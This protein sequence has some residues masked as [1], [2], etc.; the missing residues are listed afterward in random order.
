MVV[1]VYPTPSALTVIGGRSE[2]VKSSAKRRWHTRR[3]LPPSP[4]KTV[5]K[6]TGKAVSLTVQLVPKANKDGRQAEVVCLDLDNC[7][8]VCLDALQGAAYE[9]DNQVRRI[10]AEYNNEPVAGGGF[11]G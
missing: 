7:L 8:K 5:S 10:V 9:N 3:G 1:L 11:G 6:P 2:T 4:L